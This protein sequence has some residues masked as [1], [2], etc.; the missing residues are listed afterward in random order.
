MHRTLMVMIDPADGKIYLSAS[1]ELHGEFE[2]S[3]IME[4]IRKIAQKTKQ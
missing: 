4:K 3:D 1:S 2:A